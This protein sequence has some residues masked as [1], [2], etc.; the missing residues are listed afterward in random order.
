MKFFKKKKEFLDLRGKYIKDQERK[1]RI[2]ESR[3]SDSPEKNQN[4][5]L[6]FFG[7]LNNFDKEET[8]KD[9]KELLKLT[10]KIEELSNDIYHLEQRIEV[11]E[12]K[13][14]VN[15]F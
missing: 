9:S 14:R 5:S 1:K 10:E 3:K 8:K 13:L 2:L 7:S 11:L 15:N 4:D 12:A 6:N